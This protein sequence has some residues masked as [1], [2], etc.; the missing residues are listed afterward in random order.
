MFLN[1]QRTYFVI[2]IDILEDD[3]SQTQLNKLRKNNSIYK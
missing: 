3:K 2:D 1:E